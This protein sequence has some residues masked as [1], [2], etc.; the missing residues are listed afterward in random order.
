MAGLESIRNVIAGRSGAEMQPPSEGVVPFVTEVC[1]YFM[2]FLE[3]DFHKVRNPKRNIQHRNSNNLQI[4]INLNKYKKVTTRAW[5]LIKDGFEGN[6]L[7]S[8]KRGDYTTAIPHSLLNLIQEK[9]K[10]I[11]QDDLTTTIKLFHNEIDIGI[12]KNPKD[13]TAAISYALD[14]I[15]RV[16]RNNFINV[17]VDR[18]Y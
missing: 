13:T 8:L 18:I 10:L 9:I 1:R 7:S 4:S 14:G 12:T 5:R 6:A 3:T 17:F 16:I 11:S 2:D 15:S